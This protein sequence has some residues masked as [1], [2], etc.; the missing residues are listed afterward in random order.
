ME[1]A[2]YVLR[3]CSSKTHH[4]P[5]APTPL[6]SFCKELKTMTIALFQILGMAETHIE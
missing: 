5:S 6:E 2:H 3:S 4:G 1:D